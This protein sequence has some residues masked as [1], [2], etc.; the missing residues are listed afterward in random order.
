MSRLSASVKFMN[1]I[2]P[3]RTALDK[4]EYRLPWAKKYK[5]TLQN[6]EGIYDGQ[7][8]LIVCNGPSLNETPL[9]DFMEIPSIGMNKINLIFDRT[10]WRPDYIVTSQPFVVKQNKNFWN[11]TEI[12]CFVSWKNRWVM[13]QRTKKRLNF[14][15]QRNTFDFSE[16]LVTGLGQC[17]TITYTALQFAYYMKANPVIIVGM[18][19]NFDVPADT[20]RGSVERRQGA[21]KSHFDSNYF[22]SGSLWQVPDLVSTE[23]GY[24]NAKKAFENAGRSVF[25]ATV[26]GKCNIFEKISMTQ[27]LDLI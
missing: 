14:F 15:L 20:P 18:D 26:N 13:D 21:D 5:T 2:R 19:H 9:E 12:P 11:N 6:I 16:D 25:D 3:I 7:P 27:A 23:I 4:I 8:L 17:G 1:F 24:R 10:R 22:A